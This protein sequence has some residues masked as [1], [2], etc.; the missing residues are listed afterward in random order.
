MIFQG[1]LQLTSSAD[2]RKSEVRSNSHYVFLP[3]VEILLDLLPESRVATAVGFPCS[4]SATRTK[5]PLAESCLRPDRRS[6]AI[7]S[8]DIVIEVRPVAITQAMSS[9][10]LP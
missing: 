3:A 9:T 10:M 7:R 4:S 6:S 2:T 5:R 1:L 8:T